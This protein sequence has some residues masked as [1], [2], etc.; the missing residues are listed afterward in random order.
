MRY[1]FGHL[2][3]S[4]LFFSITTE[5]FG[6]SSDAELK[7]STTENISSDDLSGEDLVIRNAALEA[8]GTAAGTVVVMNAQNG[9]V[10]SIVNQDWAI[11]EGFKPCS[12]IKLVTAVG[13]VSERLIGLDGDLENGSYRLGLDDALAYSNNPYFQKVGTHMGSRKLIDYAQLLGL[14]TP[15]G[16]NAENEYAGRLPFENENL[17]IYSHADDFEVTP[18]QLAV[19]VSAITNGGRVLVPQIPR[20][21][22]K[23]ASFRGLYKNYLDIAPTLFERVIPGMVGAVNYGTA[24]G[25][26]I[27]T[28]NIAGKTGSCIY[29]NTWIGLFAS[30]APIQDPKY[31]VIVITR[32]KYARGK[33]SAAIAGKIYETLASRFGEK[34]D[35]RLAKYTPSRPEAP[36]REQEVAVKPKEEKPKYTPKV[37]TINQPE[38]KQTVITYRRD[39]PAPA[40]KPRKKTE[41]TPK[42]TPKSKGATVIVDGNPEIVR[43]RVVKPAG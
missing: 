12:T 11:R 29:K 5:A 6:Q 32:G 3:V 14:G 26:K 22:S 8:L 39:T 13:G 35:M 1:F 19:M 31:S 34:V 2:L 4:F 16:I 28:N 30:V 33:Y 9:R 20:N 41:S 10:Y 27:K 18:L 15:T 24:K 42:P 40:P 36:R 43:P 38:L 37:R 25:I 21:E 7:R 23:K 17:R